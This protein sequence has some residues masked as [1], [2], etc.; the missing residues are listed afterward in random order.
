MTVGSF[1]LQAPHQLLLVERPRQHGQHVIA[2]NN[3]QSRRGPAPRHGRNAWNDLSGK[4]AHQAD[5]DVHV[6]AEEQRI[7]LGQHGHNL[8]GREQLRDLRR[9]FVKE[10]VNGRAIGRLRGRGFRCNGIQQLHLAGPRLQ[11]LRSRGPRVARVT[12]LRKVRN[13]VR[14]FQ[15]AHR[16]QRHQLRVARPNA[17]PDEQALAAIVVMP[18][19]SG[20][21]APSC[22]LPAALPRWRW[23]S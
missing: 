21:S 11:I 6:G 9:R 14:T 8:A 20:R 22:S 2:L 15:R 13:N 12:R 18:R 4:A 16:L 5:V 3:G 1:C 19:P 17:H 7:P 23:R 10:P